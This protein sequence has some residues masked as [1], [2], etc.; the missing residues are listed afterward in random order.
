M[1]LLERMKNGEFPDGARILRAKIDMAHPQINMRDLPCIAASMNRP[2]TAREQ[3]EN[4]S[5]VR[6]G[7]C[8]T[9]SMEVSRI[10]CV[11]EYEK[12]SSLMSGFPEQLG[13]FKPAPIDFALEHDVHRD[14]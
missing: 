6:L 4:L 14:E 11:H 2:T 8:R 7:T 5:H 9:I 10:P 12:S 1:D 13:V 3:V